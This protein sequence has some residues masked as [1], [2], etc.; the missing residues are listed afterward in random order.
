MKILLVNCAINLEGWRGELFSQGV[1]SL[2][3]VL[4]QNG[5]QVE[6][7][8]LA[9]DGD[10]TALYEQ[11][12]LD[13][14]ELIGFSSTTNQ[15]PHLKDIVRTVKQL[16][17]DSFVVCGGIHPTMVPE[18]INDI[19]ELDGIVRGEGEF[20]MVELAEA[21]GNG[22]DLIH[23]QNLSFRRGAE[24]VQNSIRPP[25]DNL[26]TLPFPDT[27]WVGSRDGATTATGI[28]AFMFS[29]GCAY[30][31]SYCSIKALND[32]YGGKGHYF[33]QRSPDHALREVEL[34]V[35]KYQLRDV[36]FD[37]N[38]LNANK[39]WA[40]EFLT[41]YKEKIRLPFQ[42]NLRAGHVDAEMAEL[43]VDAGCTCVIIGVE[44]GNEEFRRRV[45]NRKMTNRQILDS[46]KHFAGKNISCGVQLLVGLP[47]ENRK[48]FLDTVRLC[49]QLPLQ[50]HTLS[51]FAPY[52]GTELYTICRD[53]H[54]LPE[55]PGGKERLEA[56]IDFPGFS[57]RDIQL[58][59][60]MFPYLLRYEWIPLFFPL[61]WLKRFVK[62]C[63]PDKE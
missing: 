46:F 7:A 58:C 3:A 52:P 1:G 14:P 6:G 55:A 61:E 36:R 20:A 8:V 4:K 34:R 44:H 51:I 42:C 15:F 54:W 13:R 11:V 43:L 59:Y 25:I 19:P 28:N 62:M 17:R 26:D 49:R 2:I 38:I 10:I 12:Q 37:D 5:Y 30:E 53:N 24:I 27:D 40:I 9:N 31:C 45:L 63:A 57:R 47:F 48:L 41:K 16:S 60:D 39:K 50:T 29:R 35:A 56:V 21:I 18:C 32:F 33:R 22:T 23:I